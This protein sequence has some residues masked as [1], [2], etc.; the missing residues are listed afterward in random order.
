MDRLTA[1]CT[2]T[3]FGG[4][5]VCDGDVG[6]TERARERYA[7]A[8]AAAMT[9]WAETG[10]RADASHAC[11]R[12][13]KR[14]YPRALWPPSEPRS[15]DKNGASPP[16]VPR[17]IIPGA[18]VRPS[19]TAFYARGRS[20]R[21]FAQSKR[22]S[23]RWLVSGLRASATAAARRRRS[24]RVLPAR[25]TP[26]FFP[27]RFPPY[28]LT[29]SRGSEHLAACPNRRSAH[30]PRSL[31]HCM[32]RP[33]PS[34]VERRKRCAPAMN[35]FGSQCCVYARNKRIR[36]NGKLDSPHAAGKP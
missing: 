17:H 36:L 15:R 9:P 35:K 5:P 18:N 16:P 20:V 13:F 29:P 6:R 25:P 27:P 1:V 24:N 26:N 31:T 22:R 34:F 33:P 11:A 32:R 28:D 4:E 12:D 30:L 23:R 19:V 21:G 10:W 2:S 7:A 8:A 14:R 3:R